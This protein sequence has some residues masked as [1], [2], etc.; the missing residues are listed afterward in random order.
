MELLKQFFAPLSSSNPRQLT[1]RAQVCVPFSREAATGGTFLLTGV[2]KDGDKSKDSAGPEDSENIQWASP[3]RLTTRAQAYVKRLAT[4]PRRG[5]ERLAFF[6]AYLEGD[7]ELLASDSY[8]EFARASYADITAFKHEI[9]REQLVA[10]IQTP[11]MPPTRKRLYLMML[12]GCGTEAELPMLEQLLRE[13]IAEPR[14]DLT[15]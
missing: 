8:D 10:W 3:I 12:S 2:T 14:R 7:E 13:K 4:L 1:S 9:D 11:E 6:Q 15:R 5:P